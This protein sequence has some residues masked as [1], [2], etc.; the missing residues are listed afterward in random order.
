MAAHSGI[1]GMAHFP[2]LDDRRC[3]ELTKPVQERKACR[4]AEN[5]H[6]ARI[7][8]VHSLRAQC[9]VRT[10]SVCWTFS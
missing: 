1:T 4:V 10:I 9:E 6:P 5:G 3:F 7:K 8:F 2:Q